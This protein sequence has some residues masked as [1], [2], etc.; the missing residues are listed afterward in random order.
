MFGRVQDSSSRL[1]PL[2]GSHGAPDPTA[3]ARNGGF[4]FIYSGRKLRLVRKSSASSNRSI[5]R[6]F[7]AD[8]GVP[9]A[10]GA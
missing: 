5:P 4:G 10:K 8:S 3:L 1:H 6:R 9:T 7:P 2:R